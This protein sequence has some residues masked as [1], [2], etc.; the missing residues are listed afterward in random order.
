MDEKNKMLLNINRFDEERATQAI[1][2]LKKTIESR[3]NN[4][5][6]AA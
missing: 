3:E 1:A 2:K 4:M 6:V 5:N